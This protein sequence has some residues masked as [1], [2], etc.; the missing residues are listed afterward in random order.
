VS[1]QFVG[2]PSDEP[3]ALRA[4]R[5]YERATRAMPALPPGLE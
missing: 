5:A 3:L 1:V 4:A 2:R